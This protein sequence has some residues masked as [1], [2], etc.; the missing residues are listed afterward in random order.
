MNLNKVVSFDNMLQHVFSTDD[1]END[2]REF[3]LLAIIDAAKSAIE[4]LDSDVIVKERIAEI[5]SLTNN[6]STK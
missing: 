6:F 3:W 1:K 5:C 2:G 4:N